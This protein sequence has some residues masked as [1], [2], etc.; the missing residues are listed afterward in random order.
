ML[1]AGDEGTMGSC[2]ALLPICSACTTTDMRIAGDAGR[3]GA[4][5]AKVLV[6]YPEV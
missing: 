1:G 4:R 5:G 2:L 6:V 3:L